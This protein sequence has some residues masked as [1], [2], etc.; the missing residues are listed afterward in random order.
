MLI[1]P[2]YFVNMISLGVMNPIQ[3]SF[4]LQPILVAPIASFARQHNY[5][6]ASSQELTLGTHQDSFHYRKEI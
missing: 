3:N 1:I 2:Y 5:G 6:Y 4:M